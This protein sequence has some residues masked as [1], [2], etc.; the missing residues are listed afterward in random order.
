MSKLAVQ[1]AVLNSFKMA[2][3]DD[4]NAAGKLLTVPDGRDEV[5]TVWS[6]KSCLGLFTGTSPVSSHTVHHGPE[7]SHLSEPRLF[8]L[9]A[10]AHDIPFSAALII[11]TVG[12]A[13]RHHHADN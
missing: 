10:G 2:P 12:R 1:R 11:P 8:H 3:A 6:P 7:V 9:L 13:S 5:F 4:R